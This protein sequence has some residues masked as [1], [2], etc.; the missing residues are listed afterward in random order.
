MTLDERLL[1]RDPDRVARMFGAISPRYDLLNR[2]LSLGLDGRWRRTAV[3]MSRPDGAR[4]VLDLAT[5]TGDLAFEFLRRPGFSGKVLGLDFSREMVDRARVKAAA[6]GFS[7]RALFRTGDALNTT[8]P[9]GSFDVVSVGFGVRNFEDLEKGLRETYRVLAP[10]GRL[11]V[12]EFFRKRES[13]IVRAYLDH[14][15]PRVGRWISGSPFAYTYLRR[16]KQGFLSPEEF[17]DRLRAIGFDP[18]AFRPLTTGVAHAVVATKPAGADQ[19]E[20]ETE[21]TDAPADRPEAEAP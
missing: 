9:D 10:G 18:V 16:S 1:E 14:V 20:T 2:L 5:G 12:V 7:D 15:L 11:V 13:A 19:P 4:R 3:E 6:R 8:E 17:A 21:A